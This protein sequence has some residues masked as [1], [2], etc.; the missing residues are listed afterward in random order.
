MVIAAAGAHNLM[1]IGSPGSSKSMLSRRL[2]TIIPPLTTAESLDTT[3]IYSAVG[4]LKPGE[5]L[6]A[7]RPFRSPHHTIS[8]LEG[9]KGGFGKPCYP[10]GRAGVARIW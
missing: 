8:V 4:Q 2:A 3:R 7:N 6:L 9:I 5:S 1:M 10:H